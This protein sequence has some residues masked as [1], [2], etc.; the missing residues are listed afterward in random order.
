MGSNK[1]WLPREKYG[2]L[3]RAYLP[4]SETFNEGDLPLS[5]DNWGGDFARTTF[6]A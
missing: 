2:E 5:Y 3:G 4:T 1:F 6:S